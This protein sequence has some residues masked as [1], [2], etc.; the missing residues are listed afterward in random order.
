[1]GTVRMDGGNT[2]FT[3]ARQPSI[4]G[5]GGVSS[6]VFLGFFVLFLFLCGQTNDDDENNVFDRSILAG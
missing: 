6:C 1:M 5:G 2:L 4:V 3:S